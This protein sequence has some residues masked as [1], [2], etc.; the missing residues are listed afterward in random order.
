MSQ[1]A[2]LRKILSRGNTVTQRSALMDHGIMALPRRIAD[3]KET[4]F[5]IDTV[6][7]SNPTT[8]QRFAQYSMAKRHTSFDG[9]MD[10]RVYQIS[11]LKSHPFNE[12]LD[13]K[14]GTR[15]RIEAI[16]GYGKVKQARVMMRLPG[17]SLQI[18]Q[19]L[20]EKRLTDG[21]FVLIH[22]RGGL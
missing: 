8:G 9:L 17:D 13:V 12:M 15:L 10:G 20:N 19:V 5:P 6:M 4:G 2:T 3:L 14:N 7:L 21:D 16:H 1:V 11:E 22:T 18:R